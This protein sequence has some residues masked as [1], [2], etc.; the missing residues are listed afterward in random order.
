MKKFNTKT[1]IIGLL[2]II[3]LF[4]IV[5]KTFG[6]SPAQSRVLNPPTDL[7]ATVAD[8][9]DVSL[10]WTEPS[11]GGST[12]LH[13]DSGEN[14]TA[15]GNFLGPVEQ[16]YVTRYD[17]EHI[18]A[19]DGW[20]ITKMRFFVV[21]PL[22]DY[23]LIIMTGP[24][25]TEV[26]SQNIP[27]VN[28][29][30]WTEI[31]LNTP[32][33][34]DASTQLWAGLNTDM[35]EAGAVMGGDEGPAIS[36][37]GDIYRFNGIWYNGGTNWNIQLLVEEPVMP[38]Y[39]H[40]D[41]GEN[42]DSFGNFLSPVNTIFAAKY[43]PVHLT[44]YDGWE[45][46]K[47]RFWVT[48]PIP[49]IKLKV[50]TGPN[51]TE[52]YSQNVPNFNFNGW[53]EIELTTPYTIDASTQ[54]WI[55]LE[56]DMPEPG[57]VMGTD[58]GPGIDGYGNMYKL[59]GNWYHD[60]SLNW[61][62]Q[63]FI[64]AADAGSRE[65][66]LGY[67]IYR[68]DNKLNNDVW[69]STSYVD[70]NLLN[71]TYDYHVTAVY[72]DGESDPSNSVEVIIDQPVIVY[73]DSMA[74]VDIYNYC[75]GPNWYNSDNWLEGP[76]NE[77]NGIT[78]TGTRVTKIHLQFNFLT[79]DIPESIGD[80]TA[81]QELRL[82]SNNITSIPETIGDLISLEIFWLGWTKIPSVP[83]SFGNLSNLKEL[84]LGQIS[85]P[86]TSLPDSFCNLESLE[87]LALGGNNLTNLPSCF[88]Q[89]TSLQ[90]CF[91]WSNGLTV[92]P[93]GIGGLTSLVHFDLDYNQLTALPDSFGDLDNLKTLRM[94]ANQ[95]SA[96]PESFADLTSLQTVWARFNQIS[97]LPEAF[98][99]LDSLKF[100]NMSYNQ[101]T[102]LP[103]SV[104]DL[105]SIT[106]LLFDNNEI[107]Y[108]PGNI[109]DLSTLYVLGLI[110]NNI[111]EVPVSIGDLSALEILGLARN[112]ISELPESIGNLEADSI[113]LNN[114]LIAELP[115]TMFDNEF[116]MLLLYNNFLQ[117]G[118]IEPFIGNVQ[119]AFAYSP[120]GRIGND[121]TVTAPSG[122]P[123]NYTI[124]VS[125][126]NNEY[127]W[128]KDG[129]MMAGQN[130]NTLQLPVISKDDEG[131]YHLEVT[132][133][134]V[135]DLT[136]VSD[137]L[138]LLVTTCVPWEF[139]TTTKVHTITI[140]ASANP[141]IGG[142]ALMDGDW[143]GVFF[144]NEN[145][146]ETCGGATQWNSSGVDLMAYGDNPFAPG[147][148]GFDEGEA[149]IWKMFRCADQLE[150]MAVA[151]YD[152]GYPNEGYF[153]N[154]GSS[155]LTGLSNGYL[156]SFDMVTG[157]N[158]ASSYIVPDNPAV[159]DILSPIVNDLIIMRNLT[160]AYWPAEQIN[161]IGNWDNT[162]GYAMKFSDG[163]AFEIIGNT[164]ADQSLTVPT[165]WSYLPVLSACDV[166]AIALFDA[167]QDDIVFVQ[168]LIG[169][170]VYWPAVGVY[171]LQTLVPGK[172]YK[173]KTNN[174]FE[175]TFPECTMEFKATRALRQ[176]TIS[177]P[178]GEVQMTPSS[179][180]IVVDA[181]ALSHF[182]N[183]DIIAAFNQSGTVCGMME[184]S[185]TARN[186]SMVFFGD[187]PTTIEA[188][189]FAEGEPITFKLYR[190][191][192]GEVIELQVEYNT[193]MENSSGL[194]Y[195]ES[196]AGITNLTTGITAIS[197]ISGTHV[198]LFPNPAKDI[199]ILSFE[200]VANQT[201]KV[202]FFNV[203]GHIVKQEILKQSQ[204]QINISS[205]K[206]GIYFVKIQNADLNKTLKLIVE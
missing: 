108:I 151:T 8:E 168:D 180:N 68:D 94:E 106:D 56:I 14:Y 150:E 13:W 144:L 123:F 16:D 118:S 146:E 154:Q 134:L 19:Y 178:W 59:F 69:T 145:T 197:E 102:Q 28:V 157:W 200:N 30:Q 80:L 185:N 120:Q 3:G 38:L 22:A 27:S 181:A 187:D 132:N 91:L 153:V 29:N 193:S 5:F 23:K 100:C 114:N 57:A 95:I 133:T 51:A 201:V 6:Q 66:L 52:V 72:D 184:A 64:E 79:G 10:F 140:P 42:E 172:A 76:V 58:S 137:S 88:G 126:E 81:L 7:F 61:N 113:Y 67:N 78:T 85:P 36:G 18:A 147:K 25:A 32:F 83:E 4:L 136:L 101:I 9:N 192:T 175:L 109:G 39:L 45:I 112:N 191:S 107:A 2:I 105:A 128:Y 65:S 148:Q 37:Y 155:A 138:E 127:A 34:I 188:D 202:S 17:P 15:F 156:Q 169:T 124:E 24:D 179:E 1:L 90:T 110:G 174:A 142:E 119:Y 122:Q 164:M 41:S 103:E 195:S 121:T 40:W 97:A 177:T 131:F 167:H 135:T 125:G 84:H 93:D 129:V 196:F 170:Q 98:G 139:T 204:S 203:Q 70:E 89:L 44:A 162:S 111:D 21:T 104:T 82:S 86:L 152:P 33:T 35:P 160:Q 183:G 166:D 194:Y 47:Y 198:H 115:S 161:T 26:Y 12:Y 60:F 31:T 173:I 73:A 189:G 163:A 116:D 92:L 46:T 48:S 62:L 165:G 159:E 99:N 50:L 74:L 96:L 63:A 186:H 117:F 75:D 190:A 176:S 43:D 149:F 49:T 171:T 182:E 206:Q 199:V 158:S 87:W 205:L 53:T 54:L 11:S 143:I 77:W 55:A 20:T 130:T 141:N 71:D